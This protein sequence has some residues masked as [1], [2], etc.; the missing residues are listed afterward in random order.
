MKVNKG[1]PTHRLTSIWRKLNSWC[2]CVITNF[3]KMA[4]KWP[5]GRTFFS[6]ARF[7]IPLAN[8]QHMGFVVEASVE[9]FETEIS[10]LR[11]LQV[12]SN[13]LWKL[14]IY[15]AIWKLFFGWNI[16]MNKSANF[17]ASMYQDG[18]S[19]GNFLLFVQT[20]LV[21]LPPT[22]ILVNWVSHSLN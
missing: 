17:T 9:W 12:L 11:F 21:P 7:L 10:S 22:W 15:F 8:Y 20:L 16:S 14:A 6:F 5:P 18:F 2:V 19:S 4:K 1:L 13:L 3:K